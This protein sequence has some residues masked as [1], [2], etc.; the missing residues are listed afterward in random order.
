MNRAAFRWQATAGVQR[1]GG[2]RQETNK[3]PSRVIRTAEESVQ[4]PP[5]VKKR[6]TAGVRCYVNRR[7]RRSR[8]R[9]CQ[10]QERQRRYNIT[11]RYD[12]GVAAP[13]LQWSQYEGG[14]VVTTAA[15]RHRRGERN[16]IEM[17]GRTGPAVVRAAP[18]RDARSCASS[19]VVAECCR[20]VL[21][22]TTAAPRHHPRCRAMPTP[23]QPAK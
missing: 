21:T 2:R 3:P 4:P 17:N 18:P 5:M 6:R 13:V 22:F 1:A 7:L 10:R 9:N 14:S 16:V 11:L 15:R 23:Q 20:R 19:P 8:W 12:G